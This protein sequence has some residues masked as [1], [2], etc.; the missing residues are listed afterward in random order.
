M[1]MGQGRGLQLRSNAQNKTGRLMFCAH[2]P[3]ATHGTVSP[4]WRSDD[5]G[6]TYSLS[7]VL[8]RGLPGNPR[9]GPDECSLV[10][11]P[12]GDVR[13]DARN[14]WC[15]FF[16]WKCR[17]VEGL[18]DWTCEHN[19]YIIPDKRWSAIIKLMALY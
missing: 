6:G 11:L 3:D 14:N 2:A 16:K 8:P 18:N 15:E 5:H 19:V 10:E 17:L 7:G 1:T 4:V 9:W 13:L 12:N